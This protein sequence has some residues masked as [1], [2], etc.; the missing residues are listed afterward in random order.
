[1]AINKPLLAIL[2]AC[3]AS[4]A[5][6]DMPAHEKTAE[7]LQAH[8]M[9]DIRTSYAGILARPFNET[10]C[11]YGSN[12]VKATNFTATNRQ[13]VRVEG[14]VCY[15]TLSM[16]EAMVSSRPVPQRYNTTVKFKVG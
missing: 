2:A 14:I 11:P 10:S 15:E 9:T 6:I 8:G 3:G 7:V 12:N 1:M 13:G 4:I 16:Q 5:V